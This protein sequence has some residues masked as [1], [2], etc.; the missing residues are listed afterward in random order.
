MR[1]LLTGVAV[2]AL[3]FLTL[4]TGWALLDRVADAVYECSE[5][6]CVWA[7]ETDP[8]PDDD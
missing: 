8:V 3:A 2:G 5:D 1:P 4:G 7:R 6:A